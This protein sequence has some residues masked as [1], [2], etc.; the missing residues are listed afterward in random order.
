MGFARITARPSG[1]V[2]VQTTLRL[3]VDEYPYQFSFPDIECA[4]AFCVCCDFA[5]SITVPPFELKPPRGAA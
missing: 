3:L 4:R 2:V 5:W 1:V